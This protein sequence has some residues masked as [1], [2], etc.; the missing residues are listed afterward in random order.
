MRQPAATL[1]AFYQSR[2]GQCAARLMSDRMVS[3]W[4]SCEGQ[5][6]LGIGYPSPLLP[7]WQDEAAT[8]IGVVPEEI[9]EA[10]LA[11]DRG[12]TLCLAPEQRLPFPEGLFDRVF[13]LHALEEADSPRQLLREAWRVLAENAV[14]LFAHLGEHL[15][16]LGE[17]HPG[18]REGQRGGFVT[19][20]KHGDGFVAHL[21]QTRLIGTGKAVLKQV[22]KR[23]RT[24]CRRTRVFQRLG[25]CTS[26][27]RHQD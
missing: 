17:Q 20:G 23:H 16:M 1:E 15:G 25:R 4:G 5:R 12:Q 27:G 18:K 22:L 7:L 26:C 9:G 14:E 19:R 24:I 8:C 3:L 13:L 11:S 10:R 6:V 21:G 2:L